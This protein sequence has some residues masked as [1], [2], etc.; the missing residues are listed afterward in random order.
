MDIFEVL[1]QTVDQQSRDGDL[2]DFLLPPLTAILTNPDQYRDR[3][4]L[5]RQL[6]EQLRKFGPYAGSGCFCDSAGVED[7]RRTL[8]R[9]G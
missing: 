5:L 7:I 6:L 4:D 2:P 1:R 3:E 9:L 8:Q